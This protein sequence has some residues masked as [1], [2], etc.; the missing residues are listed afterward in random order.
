MSP[1]DQSKSIKAVELVRNLFEHIHGNVGLLKFNIEELKPN[2]DND[3]KWDVVCSFYETL[4]S[5]N[6]SKYKAKVDLSTMVIST[7]KIMKSSNESAAPEKK[8][9]KFTEPKKEETEAKKT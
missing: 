4:G 9:W 7:E 8:E 1:A 6:P 3:N 2:E 5:P